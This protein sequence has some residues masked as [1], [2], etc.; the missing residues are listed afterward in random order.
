MAMPSPWVKFPFSHPDSFQKM[1]TMLDTTTILNC[2]A[3]CIDW[4]NWITF[5]QTV[6]ARVLP[7]VVTRVFS[8]RVRMELELVW[9]IRLDECWTEKQEMRWPSGYRGQLSSHCGGSSRSVRN[10]SDI[11]LKLNIFVLSGHTEG[12]LSTPPNILQRSDVQ[13]L[14]GTCLHL[15]EEQGGA[16]SSA[17]GDGRPSPGTSTVSSLTRR[18][19]RPAW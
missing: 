14:C 11:Y 13:S 15:P 1:L 8:R 7:R 2:R 18:T 12:C 19:R 6:W 4:R 10:K 3:V 5:S 17:Q 16:P 9:D